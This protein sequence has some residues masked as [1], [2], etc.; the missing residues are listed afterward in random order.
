MAFTETNPGALASASGARDG[1]DD[2]Q[3]GA[4]HRRADRAVCSQP[5]EA[6]RITRALGGRWYGSYGTALCP[7]HFNGCSFAQIIA[8]LRA[9]GM[10]TPGQFKERNAPEAEAR[11]KRIAA[12]DRKQKIAA[13]AAIWSR[14]E[15]IMGSLGEA[16]LR[17]RAIRCALAATLRFLPA[18]RHP[19]GARVCHFPSPC[20]R[21]RSACALTPASPPRYPPHRTKRKR[22]VRALR[23]TRRER[24]PRR[25]AHA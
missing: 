11:R 13:A 5:G 24:P 12:R 17:G 19:S 1:A 20:D 3:S 4:R 23:P 14:S 2:W 8:A 15:S 21:R 25:A 22:N 7:A 10:Q 6:E 18:L 16:Y 9:R